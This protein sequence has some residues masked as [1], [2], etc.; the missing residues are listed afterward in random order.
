MTFS[1][2]SRSVLVESRSASGNSSNA[3][4]IIPQADRHNTDLR[5]VF[6]GEKWEGG[7]GSPDHEACRPGPWTRDTPRSSCP[8]VGCPRATKKTPRKSITGAMQQLG[9]TNKNHPALSQQTRDPRD[10]PEA[11]LIVFSRTPL[12]T[13]KLHWPLRP[14]TREALEGKGPQRRP[15]KRLDMRLSKRLWA[16]TVGYKCH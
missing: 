4:H 3:R 7:G 1:L 8:R 15:Q 6:W 5:S 9:R 12:S 11:E 2:W 10:G 16:V 14:P 13:T